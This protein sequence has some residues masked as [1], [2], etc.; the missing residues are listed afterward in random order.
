MRSA[1][2]NQFLQAAL[3]CKPPV[4]IGF[5]AC[6]KIFQFNPIFQQILFLILYIY[7]IYINIETMLGYKIQP[8]QHAIYLYIPLLCT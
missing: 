4:E 2:G 7:I 3:L 5:S 8:M 1:C 6:G